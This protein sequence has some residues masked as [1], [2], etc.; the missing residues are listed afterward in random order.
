M[1]NVILVIKI[2]NTQ[3]DNEIIIALFNLNYNIIYFRHH[4]IYR[5][6]V[7]MT[8]EFSN[9]YGLAFAL[10]LLALMVTI[11]F[12]SY[13]SI[14]LDLGVSPIIVLMQFLS[15]TV[16]FSASVGLVNKVNMSDILNMQK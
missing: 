3:P 10:S 7:D 15:A 6:L 13:I 2:L 12:H 5:K 8:V 9:S 11:F 4:K 14:K 16:L 1:E